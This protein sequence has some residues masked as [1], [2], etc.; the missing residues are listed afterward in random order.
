MKCFN[1]GKETDAYLCPDC[2]AEKVLDK[3]IPQMLSYKADQCE[4]PHLVEYVATLPEEREV[5]KCIPQILALLPAELEEYYRCLYYRY[6]AKDK[7]ESAIVAYLAKHDWSEEKS[8]YLIW[9]LIG[10]YLPND[11]VKPRAWC[12]WIAEAEGVSCELYEKA[13]EYFAMIG[14]YNLSDQ[15]VEKGLACDRFI[16]STKERMLKSLNERKIKTQGYRDGNPYWPKSKRGESTE[17]LEARRRAV[18]MFY[19]EKGISYPRI[20]SKPAKVLENEFIQPGECLEAPKDYCAFWCAEAFSVAVSK[21][22]YQ[23]AAVKVQAG[24][25]TDEF[26]SFVRPWDANKASRQSAAKEAGVPLSVIEGAEDVDQVMVK[27]FDFVGGAVLVST[28][29]LGDQAKLLC[30]AAR[31]ASMKCLPNELYDLLDLAAETDSKFDLKNNNRSYILQWFNIAE[32]ADALGKAKANVTLY[33][34]LMNYKD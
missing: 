26:Q 13:A 20:E 21:P 28:G 33:E 31:Y 32:G 10:H 34:A 25:I 24:K 3:L 12:D 27:F 15:M 2:R 29:A 6:E 23:I 17:S 7:V 11:F 16:Y 22:I 9:C 14:E 4:F 30:R 19:D 1:C 18:A 8:Q 5:R